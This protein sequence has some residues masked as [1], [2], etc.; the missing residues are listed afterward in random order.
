MDERPPQ[1]LLVTDAD[2]VVTHANPAAERLLGPARRVSCRRLVDAKADGRDVC[3]PCL[4]AGP[5]AGEQRFH[6][7]VEVRGAWFDLECAAVGD[8]RVIALREA[9]PPA[10]DLALTAREREILVLVARG[11][12]SA[13]IAA[14]LGRSPATVRTHVEHAMQKLGV[15]SRPQAV[16]RAL[17]LGLID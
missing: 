2:G 9:D 8:T 10:P 3:A 15:R 1:P 12:T 6:G 7:T 4:T 13:R 11:L 5:T 17:A 14:R 16:A